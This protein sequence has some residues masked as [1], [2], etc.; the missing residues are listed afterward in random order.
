MRKRVY[1]NRPPRASAPSQ[2][3][4][5]FARRMQAPVEGAKTPEE[6]AEVMEKI[7]EAVERAAKREGTD[8]ER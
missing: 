1:V 5:D 2:A 7:G 3:Q 6:I 4:L 8:E